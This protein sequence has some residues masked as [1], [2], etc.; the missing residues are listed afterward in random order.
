MV[1]CDIRPEAADVAE[2]IVASGGRS[3]FFQAD[4]SRSD[5]VEQLVAYTVSTYGSLDK[6]FNN[7]GIEGASA[8][9]QDIEHTVWDRVI[10][11]NL[12]SVWLCL[13]Y[14]LR[15]M[16]SQRRPAAIVNTASGGGL[17]GTPLMGAYCASK[18]GI[19]GLTKTAALENAAL[20]I[21]VNAVCPGPVETPM[22]ERIK[23]WHPD[24]A[25]TVDAAKK[26][27]FVASAEEVAAAAVWL[28]SAAASRVSGVALAVDGGFTAQ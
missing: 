26:A 20:G 24:T 25:A 15:Q 14:E 16:Q 22:T 2:K 28:C 8:A 27:G 19:V 7:A 11:T 3:S 6:A 12:T 23:A 10:A 5:E 1:V 17:V 4:V 18:H 9:I 21:R 13:K